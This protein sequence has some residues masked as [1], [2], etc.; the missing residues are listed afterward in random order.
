MIKEKTKALIQLPE[1]TPSN[2]IKWKELIKYL[3]ELE[4]TQ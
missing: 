3:R 4:K 1:R 2:E